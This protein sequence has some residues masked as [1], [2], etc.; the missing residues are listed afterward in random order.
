MN[1]SK[2]LVKFLEIIKLTVWYMNQFNMWL[3]FNKLIQENF[4]NLSKD[5]KY[6]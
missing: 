6:H 1:L 4:I 3:L 5:A 2:L